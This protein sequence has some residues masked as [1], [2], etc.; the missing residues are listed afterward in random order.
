MAWVTIYN[1]SLHQSLQQAVG[2]LIKAWLAHLAAC[3]TSRDR[4]LPSLLAALVRRAADQQH[5]HHD[6][7]QGPQLLAQSLIS[8]TS[9]SSFSS[10]QSPATWERQFSCREAGMHVVDPAITTRLELLHLS[11]G[12]KKLGGHNLDMPEAPPPQNDP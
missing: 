7:W 11:H 10:L 2:A 4:V 9:L 3:S 12:P 5:R 1:D 6:R 8:T